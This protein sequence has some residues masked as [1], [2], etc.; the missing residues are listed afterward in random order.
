M[1]LQKAGFRVEKITQDWNA[2]TLRQSLRYV[3]KE[4]GDLLPRLE[5]FK[6]LMRLSNMVIALCGQG[7]VIV[8]WAVKA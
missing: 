5:R 6:R 4:K 7:D 8:A 3:K 1:L 2:C